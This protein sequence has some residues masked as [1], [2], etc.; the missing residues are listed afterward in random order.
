[1][2]PF[3]EQA[4]FGRVLENGLEEPEVAAAKSAQVRGLHLGDHGGHFARRELRDGLDVGAVLVAEGRVGQQILDGDQTFGFEHLGAGGSDAFDVLERSGSVQR[5][6][7]LGVQVPVYN[8]AE[9]ALQ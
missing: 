9:F 4:L 7:L 8:G 1:M 6:K 3:G 5:G 2:K